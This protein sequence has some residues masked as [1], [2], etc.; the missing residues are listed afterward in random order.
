MALRNDGLDEAA[1]S[2]RRPHS[3]S[4]STGQVGVIREVR[5]D[6]DE[7]EISRDL[8]VR[9][10]RSGPRERVRHTSDGTHVLASERNRL[11]LSRAMA[12]E[13]SRDGVALALDPVGRDRAALD[14]VRVA[15]EAV[16]GDRDHAIETAT[17]Q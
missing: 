3:M 15:H 13:V 17:T 6:V 10:I 4:D 16:A 1:R 11:A 9:L 2:R 7:V 12:E 14:E 5:I 8:A